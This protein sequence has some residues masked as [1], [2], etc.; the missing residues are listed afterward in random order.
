MDINEVVKEIQRR[1]QK[2]DSRERMHVRSGLIK[3]LN[4][5]GIPST[6]AMYLVD[7]TNDDGTLRAIADER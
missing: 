5:R 6:V 2:S 4:A 1:I 7:M 3:D